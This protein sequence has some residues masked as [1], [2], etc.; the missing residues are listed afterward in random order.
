MNYRHAF[1]AGNFAD[2]LKHCVLIGLLDALKVK[3]APFCYIDTHAGRGRYNLSGSEAQKTGE[4]EHGVARLRGV[5]DL[6]PLLRQYLQLVDA[7]GADIYP[8]SPLLAAR[9]LREQDT[10]HLCETQDEEVDGLRALLR[11]DARMHAHHR[12]GYAALKGLL[13]PHEKRGLVLIDPPYEAQEGEFRRICDALQIALG[14]WPTGMY[15]VWYPIK[16]GQHLQPFQRWLLNCGARRVLIAELRLQADESPLRLNG[17]GMALIN[18]PWRFADT[19]QANL[20]TLARL[21]SRD[22][23]ATSRVLRL[24]DDS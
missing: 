3:P 22:Q 5:V 10:A 4:A 15:A 7:D 9:L 1:H 20:P 12:D 16:L 24:I 17:A 23:P 11:N 13:P 8:G 2:V 14:R 18:P 19:L 21:L 6:P